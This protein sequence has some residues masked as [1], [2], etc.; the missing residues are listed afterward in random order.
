[1]E[2][3]KI[4]RK[5]LIEPYIVLETNEPYWKYPESNSIVY[6]I[7]NNQNIKVRDVIKCF[8][9]SWNY[10][11]GYAFNVNIQQ[12]VDTEDAIWSKLCHP[13]EQFLM[14]EIDWVHI[15]TSEDEEGPTIN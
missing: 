15:Y 11:E 2:L 13:E 14:P 5:Y 12:R 8:P 3:E 10:S 9:I 6:S 7:L 1:M 4:M